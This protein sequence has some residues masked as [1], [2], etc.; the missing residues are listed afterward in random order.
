MAPAF[1][2]AA[3][4][5]IL[6]FAASFMGCHVAAQPAIVSD[7]CAEPSTTY[8]VANSSTVVRGVFGAFPPKAHIQVGFISG[9]FESRS[10]VPLSPATLMSAGLIC[11]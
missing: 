2:G 1:G 11:S 5:V 7:V 9:H 4:A 8:L 6:L 10:S 3:V